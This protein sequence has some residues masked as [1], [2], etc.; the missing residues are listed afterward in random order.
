MVGLKK[1]LDIQT[2][3]RII[4]FLGKKQGSEWREGD[5]LGPESEARGSEPEAS[6]WMSSCGPNNAQLEQ[7]CP[8]R[9]TQLK[10]VLHTGAGCHL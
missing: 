7:D 5:R 1:M 2:V 9:T 3:V 6:L 8:S 4:Y 10:T